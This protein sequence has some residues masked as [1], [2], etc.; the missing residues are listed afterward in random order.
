MIPSIYSFFFKSCTVLHAAVAFVRKY[1]RIR[2]KV[3]FP[4]EFFKFGRI[5]DMSGSNMT[6]QD[7]AVLCIDSYM[8]LIPVIGLLS[9]FYPGSIRVVRVGDDRRDFSVSSCLSSGIISIT[10]LGLRRLNDG[11]IDNGPVRF[12]YQNPL[13]LKLPIDLLKEPLEE[14]EFQK[15][16][17]NRQMVE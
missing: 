14:I 4:K 1:E 7:K 16:I 6:A 12:P 3:R 11:G 2:G 17:L 9:F 15:G 8:S 13:F 5:G 10:F